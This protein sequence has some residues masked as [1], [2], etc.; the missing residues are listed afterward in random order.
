MP[1]TK[2]RKPYEQVAFQFSHHIVH[3]DGRIAHQ[4]EYI[5]HKAGVFPNFE[6]VRILKGALSNDNGSV[7]KFAK[8]ENT[9]LNAIYT[10]LGASNEL[11]KEEL[12]DFIRTITKSVGKSAEKW[13]GD[14]SMIDLCEAVKK[15][16]Y[17]PYMKGSYSIKK[18]LPTVLRVSDHLYQKYSQ[19]I[20]QLGISSKN[21]PDNHIWIKEKD[22]S[23]YDA[24][25][26]VDLSVIKDS[27]SG[28]DRISDGGAALSAYAKLQYTNM[29]DQEREVIKNALLKYCELDTL[30]MVMIWE[31]FKF[32]CDNK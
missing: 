24:L 32:V 11:D 5:H 13:E 10:Q 23:P 9:I 12:R 20:G 22:V 2:G 28:I 29:S 15:Y 17:H 4:S 21:F 26:A 7:F 25:P 18:V 3:E 19:T 1:Y 31:F 30:A 8:H 6:F 27:V 16:F 14:R